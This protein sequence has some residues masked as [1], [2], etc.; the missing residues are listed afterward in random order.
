MRYSTGNGRAP[1]ARRVRS[2]LATA[3]AAAAALSSASRTIAADQ[4][5]FY[6]GPNNGNWDST[7]NGYFSWLNV[8]TPGNYDFPPNGAYAHLYKSGTNGVSGSTVF[9]NH[10]YAGTGLAAVTI[11]S[12]NTIR[13]IAPGTAM[14]VDG[15]ITV[16]WTGDAA[17]FQSD[18]SN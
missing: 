13:Q 1:C 10:T 16:G 11:D 4:I 12:G 7:P 2:L 8:T 17:F 3:A 15:A 6:Q 5:Y 14:I 9:F 18:G